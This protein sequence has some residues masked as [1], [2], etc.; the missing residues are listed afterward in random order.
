M[1][2]LRF[3]SAV[4]VIV[5]FVGAQERISVARSPTIDHASYIPYFDLP[6]RY[7]DLSLGEG[8]IAVGTE[9]GAVLIDRATGLQTH[10]FSSEEASVVGLVAGGELW[11]ILP[12]LLTSYEGPGQATKGAIRCY[13]GLGLRDFDERCGLP[14]L[15]WLER[16]VR[17]YADWRSGTWFS[18]YRGIWHFDGEHCESFLVDDFLPGNSVRAFAIDTLGRK[19]V[20]LK[21]AIAVL[22]AGGW[23]LYWLE[24]YLGPGKAERITPGIAGDVW[25]LWVDSTA[26]VLKLIHYVDGESSVLTFDRSIEGWPSMAVD[27]EGR[28]WI[29]VGRDGAYCLDQGEL[30]HY[31]S[32]DGLA[33]DV[34]LDIDADE[35][36]GAVGFLCSLEE[37]E[38]EY[39]ISVLS[40]G[41]WVTYQVEADLPWEDT[42]ILRIDDEGSIWLGGGE[43]WSSPSRTDFLWRI[44]RGGRCDSFAPP[45]E[46]LL[47]RGPAQVGESF[48]FAWAR[49][50]ESGLAILEGDVWQTRAEWDGIPLDNIDQIEADAFGR[51]WLRRDLGV[52]NP[53]SL[54][55]IWPEANWAA[56]FRPTGNPF[57]ISC[58]APDRVDDCI[59]LSFQGREECY[60]YGQYG[61]FQ[62]LSATGIE[63]ILENAPRSYVGV[64]ARN[65]K[66]LREWTG[67]DVR[68]ELFDGETWHDMPALPWANLMIPIGDTARI[69]EHSGDFVALLYDREKKSAAL[70]DRNAGITCSVIAVYN[71]EEWRGFTC[72]ESFAQ[73][74]TAITGVDWLGNYWFGLNVLVPE[75]NFVLAPEALIANRE[76]DAA[77]ELTVSIIYRAHPV[78]ADIYV[79]IQAPS[80]QVFY[81]AGQEAAPPFPIFYAAFDGSTEFLQPGPSY[82]GPGSIPNTPD[83]K[84]LAPPPL[85]LPDPPDGQGPTGLALFAYPVP[86]FA[87]V[88]LPAYGAIADLVLLNTTL[89]N[90]APAGAYTFYIGLTAPSSISNVYRSASS[91]FEVSNE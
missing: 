5:L 10:L 80:G 3:S 23:S 68:F 29:E 18:H 60:G 49:P 38:Y 25:V 30:R 42:D 82:T 45:A 90:E 35:Q 51:V 66:W 41:A 28:L 39:A 7:C 56:E 6:Y 24:D 22:D 67:T 44:G 2:I 64:D 26:A 40:E 46:S 17:F 57:D 86:Y 89:P 84:D 34:V 1:R 32:D 50:G 63:R 8:W 19:W 76:N 36:D 15:G 70:D 31:T 33:S 65:M 4:L 74:S 54:V 9:Q 81:I 71:G 91:P 78:D 85:P 61:G 14:D 59:W 88:P 27:A 48:F 75:E 79:G 58:M 16:D 69:V 87:N 52:Y 73:S 72:P 37:G 47:Y 13:D 77:L 53:T 11:S 62:K 43:A 20:G 55:C 21:G 12:W 83:M